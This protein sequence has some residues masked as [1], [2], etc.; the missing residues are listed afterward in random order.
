MQRKLIKQ[1]LGGLTCSIPAKWIK[2]RNLTA[3][4]LIEI[5]E[6]NESLIISSNKSPKK[7]EIEITLENE[8]EEF[9]RNYL[10]QLYRIGY[11]KIKINSTPKNLLLC[12]KLVQLFLLGFEITK[13][14]ESYCIAEN[15]HEPDAE[16]ENVIF[17]RIFFIIDES[18]E[19][20]LK[21]IEENKLKHQE[22][23]ERNTKKITQ[24]DNFCK[25][26]LAKNNLATG[27]NFFN[28]EVNSF[29]LLIQ[30]NIFHFYNK[31]K[32][33]QQKS[34]LKLI[35]E[36]A[37]NF[38]NIQTFFFKKDL[39]GM[40]RIQKEANNLYLKALNDEE[41]Y[42]FIESARLQYLLCSPMVSVILS[43]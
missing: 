21:D 12:K 6:Q 28:W 32:N 40:D 41:K 19:L 42:F 38:K 22:D 13:E 7:Q 2:N 29:L 23:I 36:L 39:A 14:K 26:S 37:E 24:Y 1:G 20:L 16:K 11:D 31:K 5:D 9:I 25:R 27:K 35:R 10:N 15:I 8:S 33:T 17:R 18:Y 34:E 3:G 4:D 30:H 43:K